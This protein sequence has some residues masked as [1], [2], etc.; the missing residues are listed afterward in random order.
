MGTETQW[1][2]SLQK[3][4]PW[5]CGQMDT[6]VNVDMAQ[7]L[8]RAMVNQR[9]T[10]M[11][12]SPPCDI[13][14]WQG[15]AQEQMLPSCGRNRGVHRGPLPPGHRVHGQQPPGADRATTTT[16]SPNRGLQLARPAGGAGEQGTAILFIGGRYPSQSQQPQQVTV[17]PPP[18]GSAPV[19]L[20]LPRPCQELLTAKA[21]AWAAK[22]LMPFHLWG[23]RVHKVA[24]QHC[25]PCRH[26]LESW[27]PCSRPAP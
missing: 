2:P 8:Q 27:L 7:G 20:S 17:S 10:P 12:M 22:R 3:T 11:G 18:G 15:L 25:I 21:R 23:S 1:T 5:M 16:R 26:W 24:T 4:Q 14:D 6:P 9:D 13:P 19:S